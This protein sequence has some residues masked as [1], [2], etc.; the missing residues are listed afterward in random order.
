MQKVLIFAFLAV[1]GGGCAAFGTPSLEPCNAEK[2]AAQADKIK[3]LDVAIK[4]SIVRSFKQKNRIMEV[5]LS[6]QECHFGLH[7]RMQPI[8]SE[9]YGRLQAETFIRQVKKHAPGE[10][11]PMPKWVGKGLYDFVVTVQ[12]DTIKGWIKGSKLYDKH[13][14]LWSR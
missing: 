12:K 1:V 10:T 13:R 8:T 2:R 3:M 14:I 4:D 5:G 11:P 6:Q 9:K 7:M